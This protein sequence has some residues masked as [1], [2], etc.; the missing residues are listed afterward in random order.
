MGISQW[1]IC[2]VIHL[3]MLWLNCLTCLW[4]Y[5]RKASLDQQLIIMIWQTKQP[6]KNFAMAMLI[7][8]ECVP[9]SDFF[10][11]QYPLASGY[12]IASF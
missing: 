7:L 5:C 8:T 3:D 9:I 2:L 6:L 11:K 1:N 4:M 12:E 10:N